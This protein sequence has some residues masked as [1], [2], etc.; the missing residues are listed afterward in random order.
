MTLAPGARLGPYEILALAGGG[1]MGE[2]YRARD[3][4]LKRDVAIKILQSSMTAD[5][6]RRA[7]FER[8]AQA[9]S[10]LSHPSICA[11][12]D[13]GEDDGMA[14][15][16]IEYVEGQSLDRRLRAGP[17]PVPVALETAVQIASAL[18][19]AH[20]RG[21]VH[22]DLKPA[23]VM[24]SASGV[25]LLDF[26]VAKLLDDELPRADVVTPTVSLTAE[27]KIVGTL[28][29]MSPEQVDGRAVDE[30]TDLFAF[31][32]VLYEMLTGQKAF[33]GGTSASIAAAILTREP[34]LPAALPENA[35]P[36]PASL[37]HVIRRALAKNP[38][39]RWQTARDLMFELRWIMDVGTRATEPIR[40]SAP[41]GRRSLWLV[42]AAIVM[43]VVGGLAGWLFRPAGAAKIEDPLTVVTLQPPQGT[44]FDSGYGTLAVSPD[45]QKIAFVGNSAGTKKLWIRYL[46]STVAQPLLGTDDAT[47]PFWSPDNESVGYY[48]SNSQR[49]YRVDIRGGQPRLI[50]QLAPQGWAGSNPAASWM[51]DDTIVFTDHRALV[52]V[53]ASGGTASSVATPDATKGERTF[54]FP[55]AI[56]A[57]RV[58]FSVRGM[59]VNSENRIVDTS[60]GHP[61]SLPNILSNAVFAGGY[62]IFRDG[63]ALVAQQFDSRTLRLSGHPVIL[64][65]GVRYNPASGRTLF[66]A[67]DDVLAYGLGARRKLTWFD[68][69]GHRLGSAGEEGRDWDPVLAGDGSNRIVVDRFDEATSGFQIWTIDAQGNAAPVTHGVKER[70]PVWSPDMQWVAYTTPTANGGELHRTRAS[71]TGADEMLLQNPS[72]VLVAPVDWTRDGRF[73][74]FNRAGDLWALPVTGDR[75]PLQV[76]HTPTIEKV[77]RVSP[78][79]KWLAFTTLA[80]GG[81]T[82]WVQEFPSG[83]PWRISA[84]GVEP[85][86]RQDGKEL[87]YI[88]SDGHLTV[89]PV[90]SNAPL[91]FGAPT[92]LFQI[93]PVDFSIP[94]HVYAAAPDGQRFLISEASENDTA[95]TVVVHWR[96]L[97]RQ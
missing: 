36:L 96:A 38:D 95:I 77:G 35:V 37:E 70:F 76:T 26:G 25:K 4:R 54:W 47:G 66:S 41:T 20:D 64:A 24:L 72:A 58:L 17:L 78:D 1:G 13:V 83:T 62:L 55:A 27:H 7:R 90:T 30:R 21:I 6:T 44:K 2:V 80:A 75:Q 57:D 79:G 65:S 14:Y 61:V 48:A 39:E 93:G 87:Y 86:W 82:L 34:P 60:G 11:I 53:P 46:K 91:T 52:R 74:I 84:D 43:S 49:I 33:E 85:A 32:A 97:L 59:Q 18:V 10:R 22:R 92:E 23:N 63:A 81:S 50:T 31:G 45:G 19:A 69:S 29:Y 8:E 40:V 51:S 15:L 16:V 3:L 71:G 42:L 28:N 73:I 9:I 68:R 5:P 89:L 67:S 88:T 56:G 94:L 12:Y